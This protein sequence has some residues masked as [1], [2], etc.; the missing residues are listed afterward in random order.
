MKD[1]VSDIPFHSNIDCKTPDDTQW[2]ILTLNFN[3]YLELAGG[4]ILLLAV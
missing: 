3:F 4:K 2:S 1:K